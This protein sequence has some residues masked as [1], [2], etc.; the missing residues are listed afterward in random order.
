MT[1]IT[2]QFV[3]DWVKE[4]AELTKPEE[5]IWIDGSEEQLEAIQNPDANA[6][7]ADDRTR[8]VVKNILR[9]LYLLYK[10]F[11]TIYN[12][13]PFG[14]LTLLKVDVNL[15]ASKVINR[16]NLILHAILCHFLNAHN[17]FLC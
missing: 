8:A 4:M 3:N 13:H 10:D 16:I 12:I 14:Q 6:D 1:M 7:N 2:N 5:I 11:F 15:P 9:I 17:R